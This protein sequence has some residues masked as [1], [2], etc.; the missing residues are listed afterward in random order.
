MYNIFHSAFLNDGK[1]KERKFDLRI[2]VI[3]AITYR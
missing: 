2:I 1:E 3:Y